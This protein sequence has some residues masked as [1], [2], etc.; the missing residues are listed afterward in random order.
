MRLSEG[1]HAALR[2][3]RKDYA[4][5]DRGAEYAL[6]LGSALDAGYTIVPL[7]EFHRRVHRA[8]GSGGP[9][10]AL[11][12]DVDIRN[13]AGNEAFRTIERSAGVRSTFYFRRSTAASH[14]SLIRE[15]LRDGFEVGYHFEEGAAV[16][17]RLHL[18]GRD[19][20]L[21]GR[22]EA[23]DEFRRNCAEFRRRWNPDLSSAA[24]H[25]DWLNRR[26]A[27]SNHELV[28]G[29]LLAECGLL[30][31]AYG[32]DLMG[33]ADVYV[34]D[35]ASPPEVWTAGYGLADALHDARDPIYMLTHERSWFPSRRAS[36]DADL[37]R[38]ADAIRYRI[39]R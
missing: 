38:L 3:V 11:R 28:S 36:A 18:R 39:G 10:L 12:H 21:R 20:V 19:E 8:E 37:R 2:R 30:F 16:A 5:R 31:E 1:T 27:F 32:D 13:V 14:A 26:L 33:R 22:G 17:K 35:V 34:S 29:P 7:A 24:A 15:L 6:L 23:E 9:L 25:G 4:G